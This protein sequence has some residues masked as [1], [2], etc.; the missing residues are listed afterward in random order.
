MRVAFVHYAC[1]PTVG[2]VERV[3]EQQARS[4]ARA[5]HEVTVFARS[6]LSTHSRITIESV[7]FLDPGHPLTAA[8]DTELASGRAGPD[9]AR[10]RSAFSG[11]W[12]ARLS[13]FDAVVV[14]NLLTMHFNLAA[15]ASFHD[16]AD[17]LGWRFINWIHDYAVLNPHYQLGPPGEE[18]WNF[19]RTMP[20]GSLPVAVSELRRQQYAEVTG[21]PDRACRVVPNG[22]DPAEILG[23]PPAL[24]EALE[25]SALWSRD[26]VLFHPTR[27]LPR[28]NV[29]FSIEVLAALRSQGTDALLLL[30]G[31]PDPYN[32]ASEQYRKELKERVAELG[33]ADRVRFVA[34]EIEVDAAALAGLYAVSDALLFPSLQEGFGLPVLEA[35]AHRLPVFCSDIEPL[36]SLLPE[37][38]FP[39]PL[40]SAPGEVAR[41]IRASLG[42]S[43]G[44]RNRRSLWRTFAW[45]RLF[46]QEI[47]PLLREGTLRPRAG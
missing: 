41:G 25:R 38:I 2:G 45:E 26:L 32:T 11:Y 9:F 28:K 40:E 43:E 44:F 39:F 17:R 20:A 12:E 30:T 15:T 21:S 18:P 34:E 22:I 36:R 27:I 47:E 35:A 4:A 33:L 42:Q 29:A 14:H 10:C 6:G 24:A 7:P 46:P 23:L 8:S 16:L 5:G 13:G 3:I 19:L 37:G 31:A 1:H